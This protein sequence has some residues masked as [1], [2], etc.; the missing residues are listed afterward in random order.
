MQMSEEN[1]KLENWEEVIVD[2]FENK[3]ENIQSSNPKIP[4]NLHKASKF[5]ADKEKAIESETNLK[6]VGGLR[7][8]KEKKQIELIKLRKKAPS[9]EI[10]PWM[11]LT[12]KKQ[13]AEGKRIIK[14]THVL[15]FSHGSSESDGFLLME[16]A[17]DTILTT[18]S[19]K[20]VLTYDLAHNNGALI[21]ISRFLALKLSESLIIDLILEDD[22]E[23]MKPFSESKSQLNKWIDGFKNLVEQREIKTTDKAK[24]IYFPLAEVD[25]KAGRYHLIAPL[26]PSSLAEEVYAAMTNLKYGKEQKDVRACRKEN[27][28][29]VKKSPKFHSKP[30]IDF[31]NLGIQKFGGAQ[32]QNISML[33]K[34]RS[35]QCFLLS[36]QPPTWQSRLKSPIYKK[37]LF[38]NFPNSH[39]NED[40]EYLREFLL[41]FERIALSVK[42]PKRR[43]WIDRWVNSIIDELFFYTSSIQSLPSGWS[44]TQDIKLKREH[45]FFLD[46]YREDEAFKIERKA[47]DWQAVV[48]EDFARWLNHKLIGKDKKFTPQ[49]KHARMWANLFEYP[50]REDNKMTEADMKFQ[51]KGKA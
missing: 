22:F 47:S 4:C 48:C 2:F 5:I 19:L 14:A 18:S 3:V 26:F 27:S 9:T 8:A 31:P 16:K 45:Q 23:F 38:D 12:S 34:N 49:R 13:I 15:K 39:I 10:R 6:K 32:P 11:D 37:S 29:S 33:N 25:S 21:T 7:E 43:E 44:N 36:T 24:Q 17:N 51:N 35:G 1:R 42:E 20:K 40:V 30:Y 50:L 41:R 46:P 28:D